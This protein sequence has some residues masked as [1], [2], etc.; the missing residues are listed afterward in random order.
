MTTTSVPI[1]AAGSP[2]RAASPPPKVDISFHNKWSAPEHHEID[3]DHC[4]MK[5]VVADFI[6]AH[7][8]RG[9]STFNL[10]TRVIIWKGIH[11]REE[12]NV[13]HFTLRVFQD[14]PGGNVNFENVHCY[15]MVKNSSKSIIVLP[16][17]LSHHVMRGRPHPIRLS[18]ER[19]AP[20]RPVPKVLLSP[21]F[22]IL[23]ARDPF[24]HKDGTVLN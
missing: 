5:R 8:R 18:K 15:V 1:S 3:I 10:G 2:T 4:G 20:L 21:A 23:G 6:T 7:A 12:D 17:H 14:L 19:G 22:P 13:Y 24:D 11:Q 16:G 9:G